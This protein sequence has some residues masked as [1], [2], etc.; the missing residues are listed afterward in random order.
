MIKNERQYRITNAQAE[1]FSDALV[2]LRTD[3]SLDPMLAE[4]EG[5]ALASELEILRAQLNEYDSLRSGKQSVI[6]VGSFDELP[7]ALVK[8]RIA[9][10]LSQ[11]D[12]AERLGMKEQQLQRY[13]STD[14]RTA[15]MA[16]LREVVE[17][18]G[19]TVR[20]EVFLPMQ[21]ESIP[22]LFDRLESV[23]IER[24][25]LMNRVFPPA[26]AARFTP[27]ATVPTH[28]DFCL[29]ASTVSRVF[30]W[31]TEEL[32]SSSP[33]RLRSEAAGIARFKVPGGVNQK[34]VS[35]YTVYAHYLALLVLQATPRLESKPI[36]VDADEC[37]DQILSKYGE[38]CFESTLSYLWDSGVP[39]LPLCDSGAF[40]GA[41]WRA[42]G[43][44][45]VVL[46]QK[47]KSLAR[48]LNDMLHEFYH[49]GQEPEQPQRTVI[50]ESETSMERRNSD[51][52]QEA[53]AFAGDVSLD[54]RAEDLAGMCVDLA[55]GR[56][57]RLK[58]SV[59]SVAEMEGVDV[60]SLANYMAFRLS[61][62]DVNWWGAATNLQPTGKDPWEIAR[63]VLISRID[64]QQLN[65]NDRE[66]LL[67]ALSNPVT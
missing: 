9:L 12:L 59:V 3:S 62:S 45:I 17:A 8:S 21:T 43:R 39:V 26:V 24:A 56:V 30:G 65:P 7:K 67:L 31:Q 41:F 60:G 66:I 38:V 40:H 63:N 18:L 51:E 20:E 28:E 14:Y 34:K 15:S 32:A 29:A 10:G 64:L 47:T 16:R 46:K 27:S 48:W 13:E 50:E 42:D 33:L 23:G 35:A 36:P 5:N 53:T 37:R 52:E 49:A 11:K 2:S 6:E 1:K 61:L 58:A 54:C 19:I 22:A 44:N 57:E 25:F 4:L 55:G